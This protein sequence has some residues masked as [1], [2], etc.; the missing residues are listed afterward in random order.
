MMENVVCRKSMRENCMNLE[1]IHP[2]FESGI[3]RKSNQS[4]CC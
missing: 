3:E 2:K 4:V 1:S